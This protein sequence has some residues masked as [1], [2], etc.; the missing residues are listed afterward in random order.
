MSRKMSAYARQKLR[1]QKQ[2][3]CGQRSAHA[4]GLRA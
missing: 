2:T 1:E 4:E 3:W